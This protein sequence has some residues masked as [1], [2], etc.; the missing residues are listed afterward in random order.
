MSR[1]KSNIVARKKHHGMKVSNITHRYSPR[2]SNKMQVKTGTTTRLEQWMV[3]AMQKR[4]CS[5]RP[6]ELCRELN[7]SLT[8]LSDIL[9]EAGSIGKQQEGTA[10][11]NKKLTFLMQL[12]ATIRWNIL[13]LDQTNTSSQF[14]VAFLSQVLDGIQVHLHFNLQKESVEL[15]EILDTFLFQTLSSVQDLP[16]H[17]ISDFC[18]RCVDAGSPAIAVKS[19]HFL[20]EKTSDMNT[21]WTLELVLCRIYCHGMG[22]SHCAVEFCRDLVKRMTPELH[23]QSPSELIALYLKVHLML[24]EAYEIVGNM[25]SCRSALRFVLNSSDGLDERL[26]TR[27]QYQLVR[28]MIHVNPERHAHEAVPILKH[29]IQTFDRVGKL[30][31]KQKCIAYL[32]YL[33]GQVGTTADEAQVAIEARVAYFR[34]KLDQRQEQWPTQC[35]ICLDELDITNPESH[36]LMCGHVYHSRCISKWGIRQRNENQTRSCPNCRWKIRLSEH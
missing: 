14:L 17:L 33:L 29:L 11:E 26:R 12:H 4:P 36:L 25:T 5:I 3:N 18:D 7:Q 6:E 1:K 15:I 27:A 19:L 10:G 23:D 32:A 2:V 8:E 9:L 31:F 35:S 22:Y 13:A 20:L 16:I 34:S 21:Q 24:A 30:E 28:N